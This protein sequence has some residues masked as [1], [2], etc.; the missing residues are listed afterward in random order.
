MQPLAGVVGALA[1]LYTNGHLEVF[2]TAGSAAFVVLVGGLVAVCGSSYY[3]LRHS[4]ML[5]VK[6]SA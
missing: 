5:P 2:V 6:V 1:A 3:R 4:G